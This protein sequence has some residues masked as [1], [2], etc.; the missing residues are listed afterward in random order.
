VKATLLNSGILVCSHISK[1][2][3]GS[4][5]KHHAF[6]TTL[7]NLGHKSSSVLWIRDNTGTSFYGESFDINDDFICQWFLTRYWW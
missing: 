2:D 4:L 1:Q 6:R 5:K 7:G 3:P